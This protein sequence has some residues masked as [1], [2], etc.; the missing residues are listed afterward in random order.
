M[1]SPNKVHIH[2]VYNA[3]AAVLHICSVFFSHLG[4]IRHNTQD[5]SRIGGTDYTLEAG[6]IDFGAT[7]TFIAVGPEGSTMVIRKTEDIKANVVH[8]AWQAPQYILMSAGEVMFSI[9]GVSFSYSQ[10]PA[11]MKAVL[12]SG[13]LLTVAFGNVIVIIVAKAAYMS[14]WAEFLL[15]AALLL[16]V[17]V[18]FSIMAYFYTYVDSSQFMDE[19]K[20]EKETAKPPPL[21][22]STSPRLTNRHICKLH[23]DPL[24]P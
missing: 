17:C 20:E 3:L 12:Q 21:R 16:A 4:P 11:T 19:D 23:T 15:F 7:Y 9:T 6:L 24:A 22:T 10:A 13:W 14:Q 1:T 18:I 8:I 5:E 2:N